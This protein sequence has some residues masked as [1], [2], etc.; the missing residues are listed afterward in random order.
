MT[1]AVAE[2]RFEPQPGHVRLLKRI[3]SNNSY[4]HDDHGDNPGQENRGLDGVLYKLWLSVSDIAIF[5]LKRD[6]KLQLTNQLTCYISHAKCP[7]HGR[8]VSNCIRDL[9]DHSMPLGLVPFESPHMVSSQSSTETMSP[10]CTISKT[11]S[12]TYL[13]KF[14]EVTQAWTHPFGGYLSRMAV[15]STIMLH[16]KCKVWEWE[17]FHSA[18]VTFKITQGHGNWRHW[19]CHITFVWAY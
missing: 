16:T 6:V 10:T 18:K 11:S 7:R 1:F 12:L 2:D 8:K 9:Q 15:L 5:V 3:I 19:L 4:A 14:Q 17:R 13:P